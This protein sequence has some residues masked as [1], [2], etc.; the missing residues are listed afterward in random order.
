MKS[1]VGK[2]VY[3]VVEGDYRSATIA[4]TLKAAHLTMF[5]MLG[6][7]HVYSPAGQYLA[8][9]LKKFYLANVGVPQA[10]IKEARD[11]YFLPL[12]SM[13]L[14]LIM[15]G[16]SS[17]QG[18]V[19]DRHILACHGARGGVFA[20]GVIIKVGEHAFCSF[21]PSDDGSMIDVYFG[22][23]REPPESISARIVQFIP[24]DGERS[25]YWSTNDVEPM[26]IP[27]TVPTVPDGS[28]SKL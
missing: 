13:V 23:L 16:E 11:A 14:P 26:R 7:R 10:S 19:S 18:T 9:I 27:L 21:L 4:S 3:L 5:S 20:I 2:K 25:P 24:E 12:S 22:F 17:L 28:A 1:F 6:Y 15:E 8:E